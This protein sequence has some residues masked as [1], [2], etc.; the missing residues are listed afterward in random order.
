M[1]GQALRGFDEGHV[2]EQQAHHS[3]AF[4]VWRVGVVPEPRKVR[5]ERENARTRVGVHADAVGLS[6]PIVGRL[7]IDDLL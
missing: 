2:F 5:R 1:C 7:G 4:P 3:F 6:V